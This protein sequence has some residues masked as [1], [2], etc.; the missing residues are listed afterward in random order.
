MSN[1]RDERTE[2]YYHSGARE[3][4]EWLVDAEEE[5]DRLRLAWTSARRRASR[6]MGAWRYLH[7][8]E[9]AQSKEMRKQDEFAQW[10]Y[11]QMSERRQQ[12][13]RY[14]LA[15]ISARRRASREA[16]FAT[17]A[18]ALQD[19]ELRR[20][21]AF[22]EEVQDVRGWTMCAS[23]PR[24]LMES[25]LTPIYDALHELEEA[26]REGRP[27]RDRWT[28]IGHEAMADQCPAHDTIESAVPQPAPCTCGNEPAT[29]AYWKAE[30][31]RVFEA[32]HR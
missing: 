11:G 31:S 27:S 12:R 17:E 14:R 5:A 8:R 28:R 29:V 16:N 10:L 25:H 20:L 1:D 18:L 21:R 2:A 6:A 9:A 3:L 22:V 23:T 19:A 32:Q 7:W 4:A 15:W 24:D 26:Q 13:D 30:L